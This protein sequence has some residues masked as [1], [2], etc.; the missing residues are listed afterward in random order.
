M[1][2]GEQEIG[3]GILQEENEV[4]SYKDCILQIIYVEKYKHLSPDRISIVFK[5]GFNSEVESRESGSLT[6]SNTANPKFRGSELYIDDISLIYDKKYKMKY[7]IYILLTLFLLASCQKEEYVGTP[8]GM[9]TLVLETLSV[10]TENV[11]TVFTRAVEPDLYVE[12]W[13]NGQL[14][15]GQRYE[16]GKVPGKL[17]LPAGVYLLKTYNQAY[18]DMS[19]WLDTEKGNMAFSAEKDFE[20]ESNEINYLSV[21]V[22]MVN[23]GVSLKL[24]EGFSDRFKD[25]HFTVQ[26]G[27]RSVEISNGET[28]YFPLSEVTY[29]LSAT[30]ND[31]ENKTKSKTIKSPVAGTIYEISYGYAAKGLIISAKYGL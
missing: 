24:P 18:Q 27:N 2:S 6:S 30:N 12:I 20:I 22:P 8:R 28:A 7:V 26:V 11:N 15:T 31:G 4:S 17:D 9:G 5:S 29:I 1:F 3:K 23:I 25:Y 13:Q 14:L 19:G 10:Q 16:P 21:E